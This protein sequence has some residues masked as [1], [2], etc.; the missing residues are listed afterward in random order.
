MTPGTSEQVL[1]IV[2]VCF[3]YN[4]L[5]D[6]AADDTVYVGVIAQDLPRELVT[7]CRH[8]VLVRLTCRPSDKGPLTL[9]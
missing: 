1:G 9:A 7:F 5:G 3:R 4:G 2:P 6:V 8:K